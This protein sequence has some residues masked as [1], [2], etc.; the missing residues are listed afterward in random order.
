MLTTKAGVSF[1]AITGLSV[2]DNGTHFMV[3]T[4]TGELFSYDL[5]ENLP[6]IGQ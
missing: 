3:G 5:L 6:S 1:G 4:E 2:L